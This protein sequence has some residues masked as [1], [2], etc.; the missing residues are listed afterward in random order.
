MIPTIQNSRTIKQ[1]NPKVKFT[2]NFNV[3]FLYF[4]H[5]KVDTSLG[6]AIY[7]ASQSNI[8]NASSFTFEGN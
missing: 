7:L 5:K 6:G 3:I 1:L 8:R 4:Y 2:I